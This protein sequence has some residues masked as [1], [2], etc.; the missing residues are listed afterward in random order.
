M[1]G[2]G[3]GEES[4][5]S[6]LGHGDD[7]VMMVL[8]VAAARQRQQWCFLQ[9]KIMMMTMMTVVVVVVLVTSGSWQWRFLIPTT[10]PEL[11]APDVHLR[12]VVAELHPSGPRVDLGS[13][14]HVDLGSGMSLNALGL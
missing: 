12:G 11:Q 2:N 13:E 4:R 1:R 7:S 3:G 6:N 14:D 5:T 8:V 9:N 10:R